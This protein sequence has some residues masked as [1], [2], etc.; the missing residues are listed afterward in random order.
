DAT[1]TLRQ[2]AHLIGQPG[3]KRRMAEPA[4]F[5]TRMNQ[6][7]I[8]MTRTARQFD[9][10]KQRKRILREMKSLTQVVR[11]HARRYRD[12]LDRP[13]EPTDWTRPQTEQVLRRL[14]NVLVQLP[15]AL[16]QAHERIMGGRRVK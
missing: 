16:R 13:W 1:R 9:G 15:A 11:A 7:C 5:V 4:R 3:L 10:K 6:G 8:K 12:L 2:A 14:D